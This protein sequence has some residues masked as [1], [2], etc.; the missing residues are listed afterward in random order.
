MRTEVLT[1]VIMKVTFFSDVMLCLSLR[2]TCILLLFSFHLSFLS[3]YASSFLLPEH[4]ILYF[5]FIPFSF[6]LRPINLFYF[7]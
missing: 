2:F 7:P 6:F 5:Y 3:S 1:A 4:V